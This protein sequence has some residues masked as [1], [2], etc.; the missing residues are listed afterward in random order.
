MSERKTRKVLI[1]DDDELIRGLMKLYMT[2]LGKFEF[3]EASNGASGLSLVLQQKPDL[4]IADIMMPVMDGVTFVREVRAITDAKTKGTPVIVVT[5]GNDELKA[6]AY[7]AGANF[8]LEKPLHRKSM[9]TAY[10]SIFGS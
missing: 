10:R 7:Q 8:V 6:R 1:I 2:G 5:G 3:I 4:I 9:I